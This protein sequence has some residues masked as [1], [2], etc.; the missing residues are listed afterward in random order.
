MCIDCQYF[1]VCI[2]GDTPR[3][4]GCKLGQVF[5]DISKNCKW[6]RQVPECKDFYK[7]RLTDAQLEELENPKPK[8]KPS[9]K[10]KGPSATTSTRRRPQK[11]S[12]RPV[13]E[14]DEQVEE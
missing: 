14:E 3:R 9:K 1:Y 12:R 6:A 11:Q 10:T 13:S 5:D 2:N 4:N 8:G 7:D